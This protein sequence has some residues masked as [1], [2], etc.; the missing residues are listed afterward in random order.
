VQSATQATTLTHQAQALHHDL[1]KVMRRF[2]RQ[3]RGQGKVF[4]GLVRQTETPLLEHGIPI[5]SLAQAAKQ[6]LQHATQLRAPMPER[7]ATHLNTALEA[8]RAIRQ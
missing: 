6:C 5:A 3:C 7:L 8:H 2:G 1:K 4:V